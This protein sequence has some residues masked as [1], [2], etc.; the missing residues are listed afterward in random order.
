MNEFSLEHNG[1]GPLKLR[2]LAS[3]HGPCVI[4]I[5]GF[6]SQDEVRPET[7]WM[8]LLQQCFK[9]HPWSFFDWESKSTFELYRLLANPLQ[10][11]KLQQ[12]A[13]DLGNALAGNHLS[14]A[15]QI[16]ESVSQQSG[17]DKLWSSAQ[18][19]AE[20]AGKYLANQIIETAATLK[21]IIIG[22]SLG[23]AATVHALTSLLSFKEK[24]LVQVHLLGGAYSSKFNWVPLTTMV[25][26]SIHNYYSLN[27]RVLTL[28]YNTMFSDE[29]AIGTTPILPTHPKIQNHDVSHWVG[30]HA[31]YKNQ[32]PHFLQL[33]LRK[34]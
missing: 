25:S 4:I 28:G 22:Y 5:N 24:K 30:N 20:L 19:N 12:G 9:G 33:P 10:Q 34:V 21:F 26:Q 11:K 13:V 29:R 31:L 15:K 2:S 7:Q 17:I 14:N 6:L 23:A 1:P 27:D 18:T 3:G 32:A 8:P 16:F